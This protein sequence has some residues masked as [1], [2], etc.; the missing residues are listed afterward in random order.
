MNEYQTELERIHKSMNFTLSDTATAA[1]RKFKEDQERQQKMLSEALGS[2]DL[3]LK[4]AGV[5]EMR[6]FSSLIPEIPDMSGFAALAEESRKALSGVTLASEVVKKFQEDQERWAEASKN[7]FGSLNQIE[8]T[9]KRFEPPK[10]PAMPEITAPSRPRALTRMDSFHPEV[11]LPPPMPEPE[12][13]NALK[14]LN[15]FKSEFEALQNEHSGNPRK[16][17]VMIATLSDGEKI[18]VQSAR[19]EGD[20]TIELI[21]INIHSGND[22]KVLAGV[23]N[24]TLEVMVIDQGP[25][26]P[27]LRLVEDEE[28]S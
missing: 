10:L 25:K 9:L 4:A 23:S 16:V 15:T 26:K 13:G 8:E 6:D 3:T 12:P 19:N 20:E 7:A 5:F 2:F 27:D 17:V 14:V 22:R 11:Y 24:I 28:D 1:L 21:G 18:N